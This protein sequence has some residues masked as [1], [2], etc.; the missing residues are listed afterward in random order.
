MESPQDDIQDAKRLSGSLEHSIHEK[1]QSGKENIRRTSKDLTSSAVNALDGVVGVVSGNKG[2]A[3]RRGPHHSHSGEDSDQHIHQSN[4]SR[5]CRYGCN[6]EELALCGQFSCLIK[7]HF[8]N[9][10]S[11]VSK[12]W[13][14]LQDLGSN[15]LG[16]VWITLLFELAV[17]FYSAFAQ[18]SLVRY[19]SIVPSYTSLAHIWL[20]F[21]NLYY[22]Y[23]YSSG[24]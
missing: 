10:A 7:H 14:M 16:F 1:L 24:S 17:F 9:C 21:M 8:A 15:S 19:S 4:H 13:Q 2:K 5:H 20:R 12:K 11:C 23:R 18:N 3:I 6:D 22:L